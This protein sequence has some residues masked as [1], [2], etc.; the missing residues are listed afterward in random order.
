MGDDAGM[1][2]YRIDVGH[3]HRIKPGNIVGAIANEAELDARHIGRVDIRDDYSLV[4]LPEGMPPELLSHLKKVRVGGQ[5]LKM[6]LAEDSDIDAPVR[7][8][9]A[10]KKEGGFGKKPSFGAPRKPRFPRE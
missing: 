10:F 2:T 6:R 4:D 1:V 5:Q 9:P 3:S 7:K 8:R